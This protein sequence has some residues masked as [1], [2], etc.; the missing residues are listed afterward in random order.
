MHQLT[1]DRQAVIRVLEETIHRLQ[2]SRRDTVLAGTEALSLASTR[3]WQPRRDEIVER[4]S[5]A[6]D[7]DR[8]E[9]QIAET[10]ALVPARRAEVRAPGVVDEAWYAPRHR[11]LALFQSA[12]DEYLERK[13]AEDPAAALAAV[14][15]FDTKDPL[16]ASVA[17]Q[18]LKAF[19]RGKARFPTH[20][21]SNDFRFQ[22]D[23]S[24]RIALVADW[25]TATPGALA[26]AREIAR[27]RPHQII[28]LGDVYYSGDEREVRK[29][30]LDVWPRPDSLQRSWALHRPGH[31]LCG[32]QPQCGAG[33]LAGGT[34]G[35]T[36]QEDLP[37]ASP[38]LLGLRER[39]REARA[40]DRGHPGCQSRRG[41]VLGTR[42]QAHRL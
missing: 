24:C 9:G 10:V 31:R 32:S 33:R 12:M 16:W 11:T 41:L 38:A 17:L 36:G 39:R 15:Q 5:N 1:G 42:A 26:V 30:M 2:E 29:R 37:V 28:H 6:H 27:R 40:L 4:L 21:S 18:K 35:G 23:D 19:F 13:S 34:G 8:R 14:E 7:W 25:G 22:L 20:R 3:V